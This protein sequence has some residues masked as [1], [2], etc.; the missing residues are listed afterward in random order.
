M[1]K[2]SV[3]FGLL[4]MVSIV[5]A[6]NNKNKNAVPEK[7]VCELKGQ[8]ID[9]EN[10]DALTGVAVCIEGTTEIAYTNFDGEF[11]F[12]NITPGSYKLMAE[13]VTYEEAELIVDAQTSMNRVEIVLMS[14]VK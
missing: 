13:F 10:G 14:V 8:I 7:K 12:Q 11:T 3:L 4:L 9:K 5:T 6:N 1:K 2:L